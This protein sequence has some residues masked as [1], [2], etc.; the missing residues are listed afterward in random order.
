MMFGI[1]KRAFSAVK[2]TPSFL[3]GKVGGVIRYPPNASTKCIPAV[4]TAA[5]ECMFEEES[6]TD[7]LRN[8][9][10]LNYMSHREW[11]VDKHTGD[12]VAM[13]STGSFAVCKS[14]NAA[15]DLAEQVF[16]SASEDYC[17]Q[18]IGCEA[19]MEVEMDGWDTSRVEMDDLENEQE[20]AL[21][22]EGQFSADGGKT[23]T[24]HRFQH[25]SGTAL[26]GVPAAVLSQYPL[27]RGNDVI[28]IGP[29]GTRKK[30]ST[31]NDIIIKIGDKSVTTA[32]IEARTWLLGFSVYSHFINVIDTGNSPK[33]TLLPRK[34]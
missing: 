26:M 19:M 12:W 33:I 30:A 9:A 16:R 25:A 10:H 6:P 32:V 24:T 29:D 17:L 3:K 15:R 1:A 23:F 7:I 34:G 2:S 27:R 11:L 31:Y 28:H 5:L 21:Y 20:D 18:C 22:V 13:S 8:Q 4:G 14:E